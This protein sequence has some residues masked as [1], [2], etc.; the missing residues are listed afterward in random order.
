MYRGTRKHALIRRARTQGM[1]GRMERERAVE[2]A[3]GARGGRGGGRRV[4]IFRKKAFAATAGHV[5]GTPRKR[6]QLRTPA[7]LIPSSWGPT[8]VGVATRRE[9]VGAHAC[10]LRGP[11]WATR[12]ELFWRART[13]RGV[14][15]S[16]ADDQEHEGDEAPDGGQNVYEVK[17]SALR[18]PPPLGALPPRSGPRW[19]CLWTGQV[20]SA[21][22]RVP[23]GPCSHEPICSGRG[24]PVRCRARKAALRRFAGK[25]GN[26]LREA[27]RGGARGSMYRRDLSRPGI[28]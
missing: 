15:L 13:G 24:S 4:P 27:A 18:P 3:N 8:T 7:R 26:M 22:V 17:T 25:G 2:P 20:S 28:I 6:A 16:R 19:L 1:I 23:R 12:Q 9:V 10:A 21:G 14:L 11:I 5:G